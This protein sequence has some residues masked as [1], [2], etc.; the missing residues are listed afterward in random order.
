[1]NNF[2][3]L[4]STHVV[5]ERLSAMQEQARLVKFLVQSSLNAPAQVFQEC[6]IHN[7]QEYPPPS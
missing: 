6:C 2:S 3:Y 1:M 7:S 5:C 4:V